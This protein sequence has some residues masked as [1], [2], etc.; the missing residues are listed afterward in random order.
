MEI[1]SKFLVLD[2]ADF[3]DLEK[4]SQLEDYAVSK[5]AVQMIEDTF[6]DTKKMSVMAEGYYLRLRKEIGQEG[7][8]LT[9]KSLGGFE[10]G[11]HRR[12]E[13]ISFL[14]ENVSVFECPDIRIK[15]RIFE[16]DWL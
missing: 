16:L 8:W 4:L 3:Q 1:E 7:Q 14:P 15:E 11:V 12:E 9:I 5:A 10:A 6:L 13:Y 2:E